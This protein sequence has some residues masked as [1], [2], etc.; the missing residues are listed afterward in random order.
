MAE[1]HD[2]DVGRL[3]V[4]RAEGILI[5]GSEADKVVVLEGLNFL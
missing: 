5:E 2:V 3:E 4:G 1:D